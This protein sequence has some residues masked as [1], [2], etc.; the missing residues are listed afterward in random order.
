MADPFFLRKPLLIVS[1]ILCVIIVA[2]EVSSKWILQAVGSDDAPGLALLSMSLVDGALA[3]TVLFMALSLI[4]PARIMGIIFGIANF[5][6]FLLMLIASCIMFYVSLAALMLMVSLFMAVPFG[7]LAYLAAF[8]SFDTSTAR[9]LLGLIMSLKIGLVACLL[10]GHPSYLKVKSLVFLVLT[11][12][13]AGL[14]VAVLH[15]F[16]PVIFVSITDALAAVII[17]VLGF[18]WSMYK[19][20][21][22]IPSML[23]GLR[24]DRH[25]SA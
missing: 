14:I 25:V 13:L 21:G 1:S 20:I 11:A 16:A 3:I 23:K 9:L 7:T 12:F 24:L 19:F 5:L 15:G 22:S 2:L 4:V 18:I 6:L 8:G 10:F 17:S